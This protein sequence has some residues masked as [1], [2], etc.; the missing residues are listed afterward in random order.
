MPPLGP[1]GRFLEQAKAIVGTENVIHYPDDLLVFEYDGSV[2]RALPQAVVRGEG[3]A[4]ESPDSAAVA[5][6]AERVRVRSST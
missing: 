4:A 5:W 6:A 3:V 2:D 1:M